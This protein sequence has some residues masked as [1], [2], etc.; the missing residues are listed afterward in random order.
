MYVEK[1]F[2]SILSFYCAVPYFIFL[3]S[4]S[5][6]A[7]EKNFESVLFKCQELMKCN[8]QLDIR[9]EKGVWFKWYQV[10]FQDESLNKM[11]LA[12]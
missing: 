1:A 11:K 3:A 12:A 2:F 5:L 9:S 10:D 6:C 4:P 7:F 8:K